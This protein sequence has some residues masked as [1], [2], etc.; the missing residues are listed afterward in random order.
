MDTRNK[1]FQ[2]LVIVGFAL[3]LVGVIDPLE[4]S[5]VIVAG[6]GLAAIGALVGGSRYLNLFTLA[7]NLGAFGVGAMIVL[8]LMGGVGGNSGRSAWWLLLV[9]PY[10]VGYALGLIV[11]IG[12]LAESWRHRTSHP[13]GAH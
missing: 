7:V 9:V 12:A 6:I 10:P 1:Y 13:H 11:G 4:G 8:S 3:M 5:V 2:I